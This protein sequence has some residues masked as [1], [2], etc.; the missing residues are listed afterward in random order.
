MLLSVVILYTEKETE[1]FKRAIQTIPEWAEVCSVFSVHRSKCKL[2]YD[3]AAQELA[4]IKQ[5]REYHG[6]EGIKKQGNH[7]TAIYRWSGDDFHFGNARNIAQQLATGEFILFLDAD[8]QI[9]INEHGKLKDIIAEM[10]EKG[11]DGARVNIVSLHKEDG[12]FIPE[13]PSVM[14]RLVKN[15]GYKF[16]GA[17]HERIDMSIERYGGKVY[18]SNLILLH[19][20]YE[21]ELQD[22]KKKMRRNIRSALL[23][24]KLIK[25]FGYHY[26]MLARDIINE[27]KE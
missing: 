14:T 11:Y 25:E 12:Q 26:N 15:K 17:C 19:D 18:S 6:L 9:P 22:L 23:E 4:S 24:P 16:I 13:K 3:N 27:R 1:Q 21:M 8:E 10:K 2:N 5:M 7:T 20:G